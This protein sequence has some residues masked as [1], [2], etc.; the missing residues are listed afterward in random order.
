MPEYFVSNLPRSITREDLELFFGRFE[1]TDVRVK[2]C[3]GR[4]P[5]GRVCGLGKARLHDRRSLLTTSTG[6]LRV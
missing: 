2:K 6:D 3:V 4:M 5:A 1:V